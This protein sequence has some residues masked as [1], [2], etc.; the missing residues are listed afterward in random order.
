M[1]VIGALLLGAGYIEMNGKN[2][3]IPLWVEIAAYRHRHRHAVGRVEDHRDHGPE[4]HHPP[5]QLR[6]GRQRR[7]VGVDLRRHLRL[8]LR[9]P[10]P[11]LDHPRRASSVVGASVAS[12]KGANWKVVGEMVIAWV[13]TI[14][15]AATVGFLV[16]WLTQLPTV[17]SWIAVGALVLAFRDVGRLGNAQQRPRADIEERSPP[18]PSCPS[19]TPT[20]CRT[21]SAAARWA[22]ATAWTSTWTSPRP[23]PG[24][25]RLHV[26]SLRPASSGSNRHTRHQGEQRRTTRHRVVRRSTL[27]HPRTH[28]A[29]DSE[30]TLRVPRPDRSPVQRAERYPRAAAQ[31]ARHRRGLP[32]SSSWGW[33]SSC[34]PAPSP[35]RW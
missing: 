30:R 19:S 7:R 4:D 21:W 18:R 13:V 15:A 23:S 26:R 14:P 24:W 27:V 1:G 35:C 33:R 9:L 28:G 29:G 22:R 20:R 8:A 17:L 6:R 32:C 16:C 25:T 2:L 10:R 34:C 11:H 31:G 3:A 5:R 12:G